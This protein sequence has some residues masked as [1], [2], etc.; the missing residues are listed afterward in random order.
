MA[1]RTLVLGCI[2]L[3]SSPLLA[4]EKKDLIV[5]KDGDRFTGEIKGLGGGTLLVSLSYV[6]GNIAVQW[7]EVA[8]LESSRLFVVKT[9]SGV[10]YTGKIAT[11]GVSNDPPI[12]IEIAESPAKE[13]EVAQ[14]K[15]IKLNP[16]FDSFW[17][18]FDGAVNTGL[19]YSKDDES[20]QFNLSSQVVYTR[21]RWSSQVDFNSSLA[22]NSGSNVTTRNQA[23]IEATKLL[24]WNHW[25][26]AVTAAFL[27][28][29]VQQIDLQTTLAA[30]VG[31]Y[32]KNTNRASMSVFGGL[33][34]QNAS[35]GPNIVDQGSQ[36]TA[37]GL[38]ATR[39]KAFKFKKTNLDVSASLIP[40]I[41][42][43][44]RVAFQCE[45]GLLY[46]ARQ[47]SLVELFVLRKLGYS[48]S[49]NILEKRLRYQFRTQLDLWQQI[50]CI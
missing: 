6:D 32:L 37:V 9:E 12:K 30:G 33:G 50:A 17:R 19:L 16:I 27:Q 44:G 40:A 26:Y 4:Q 21:E 45:C 43:P 14:R 49:G 42:G 3:C 8:H 28:S 1:I 2:F 23:D 24:R 35:Y 13:V 10:V 15:I 48:P 11:T 38:V 46:Q 5:M 41:T 34:W 31:R 36:N 47:R 18:R 39:I 29:S 25:F 20:T 7:S 22:S